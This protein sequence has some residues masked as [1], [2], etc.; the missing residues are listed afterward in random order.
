MATTEREVVALKERVERLEAIVHRLVGD[1]P[2]GTVS[3]SG[4]VPD[5]DQLLPWL[6]TQGLIREP[7]AEECRLAAEWDALP[8]E[9]KQAHIHFMHSLALDP[10][11]SQII[12]EQ[13]R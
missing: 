2:Q 12:I 10:P 8:E 6:K 1:A 9:E 7:T 3:V 13:R 5:Q 11:L 4:K